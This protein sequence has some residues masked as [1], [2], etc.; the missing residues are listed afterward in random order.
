MVVLPWAR[1]MSAGVHEHVAMAGDNKS[2]AA[3]NELPAPVWQALATTKPC[4]AGGLQ[5]RISTPKEI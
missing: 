4:L 2:S 5:T 1:G 3:A